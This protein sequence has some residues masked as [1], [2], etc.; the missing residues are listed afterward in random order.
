MGVGML[1]V[2]DGMD[3]PD[4]LN[5]AQGFGVST[6]E[7]A[8]R[9]DH[10]TTAGSHKMTSQLRTRTAWR[11]SK[12]RITARDQWLAEKAA[13]EAKAVEAECRQ[14]FVDKGAVQKPQVPSDTDTFNGV[15]RMQ[16]R[17]C[18]ECNAYVFFCEHLRA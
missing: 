18:D 2:V 16:R 13:E 11:P 12:N 1:A 4:E 9:N 3:A 7:F 5:L 15:K 10:I 14:F 8:K 6:K 17:K